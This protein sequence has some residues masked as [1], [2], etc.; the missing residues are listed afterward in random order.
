MTSRRTPPSTLKVLLPI[1]YS[2]EPVKHRG[3]PCVES[4]LA[5]LLEDGI[6]IST[7][8]LT[9][10]AAGPLRC[11]TDS[12]TYEVT[13]KGR[14]WVEMICST[15]YPARAEMWVDPRNPGEQVANTIRVMEDKHIIE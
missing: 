6:I 10:P 12:A 11:P 15:P 2:G 13:D 14:A 1:Y 3:V 5:T 8:I 4:A 7:G 9:H